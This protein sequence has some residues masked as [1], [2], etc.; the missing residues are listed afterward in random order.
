M[1]HH[2]LQATFHEHAASFYFME[3]QATDQNRL[4]EQEVAA[5]RHRL[6]AA[7]EAFGMIELAVEEDRK[8][9]YFVFIPTG[10]R[11]GRRATEKLIEQLF[12]GCTLT[13]QWKSLQEILAFQPYFG[14]HIVKTLRP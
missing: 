3:V 6:A 10:K 13:L 7:P 12:H 9:Q 5:I 2:T 8:S 4:N 11:M 14:I 1:Q